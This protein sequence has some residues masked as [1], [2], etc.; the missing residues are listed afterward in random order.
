M[1]NLSEFEIGISEKLAEFIE[2]F[3]ANSEIYFSLSTAE[4]RQLE[5]PRRRAEGSG[6]GTFG[7]SISSTAAQRFHGAG[8]TPREE[9]TTGAEMEITTNETPG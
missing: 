7:S 6:Y 5:A 3:S 9:A 4:R 8:Y 1:T 2:R